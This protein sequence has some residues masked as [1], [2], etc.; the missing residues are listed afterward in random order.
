MQLY[1]DADHDGVDDGCDACTRGAGDHDEDGDTML[2]ACDNCPA[3][4]NDQ[5]DADADGIGDACDLYATK[6]HRVAFVGFDTVPFTWIANK[7]TWTVANDTV[8]PAST[9]TMG[10]GVNDGLWNRTDGITG[11]AWSFETAVTLPSPPPSNYTVGI[12]LRSRDGGILGAIC[13]ISSAGAMWRLATGANGALSADFTPTSTSVRL[14]IVRASGSDVR[15][16]IVDGASLT[17]GISVTNI[18]YTPVLFT[19]KNAAAFHYAELVE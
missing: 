11:A 19:N 10:M 1:T 12:G 7:D 9:P 4:V 6:Q 17:T 3:I 15:C 5:L 18:A 8:G 13:S 2:D 14:R 16:E